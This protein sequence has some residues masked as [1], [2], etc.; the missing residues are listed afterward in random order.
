MERT[1]SK[2]KYYIL[3]IFWLTL[4]VIMLALPDYRQWF[5]LAL[6]GTCTYF[7]YSLSLIE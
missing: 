7:A 4:M 5:W 2:A 6:P 3:F 1:K